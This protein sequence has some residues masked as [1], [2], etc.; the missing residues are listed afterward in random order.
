MKKLILGY[1]EEIVVEYQSYTKTHN[2]A[3]YSWKRPMIMIKRVNKD[4]SSYYEHVT[5]IIYKDG[6]YYYEGT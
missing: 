6:E 2:D 5:K 3:I 4:G 1:L